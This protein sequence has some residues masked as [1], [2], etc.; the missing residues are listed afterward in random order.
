MSLIDGIALLG[1]A[2][3]LP[4][5]LR[6]RLVWWEVAAGSTALSFVM[7]TGRAG[8]LVVPFVAAAATTLV[9]RLRDVGLFVFFWKTADWVSVIASAYAV[10]AAASLLQSRSG[11]EL[12][13]VHEPIVELTAVHYTFAGCAALVLAGAALENATGRWRRI[14]GAAI[15]CTAAAPP[16]V[17]VGFVTGL[18]VPQVGGA[19]LMASGVWLTATLQLRGAACSGRSVRTV[20]LAVS[21]V[22]VWLPMVLAVAWAAGQ[23]W[24]VPALSIPDMARTHGLVNAL[25]F[26]GCGLVARRVQVLP[27]HREVAP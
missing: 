26:V 23:H 11:V 14:G 17:A 27:T 9:A 12:F 16:I 24:D 6:G 13:G 1:V 15:V 25:A 3:V 20:L 22:A 8:L 2:A 4:L 7:P 19:V 18:A 5:S 10:V 21:G